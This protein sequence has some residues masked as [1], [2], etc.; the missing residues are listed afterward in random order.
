[1]SF[2]PWFALCWA[3]HY[4]DQQGETFLSV[5]QLDPCEVIAMSPS[6]FHRVR[7]THTCMCTCSAHFKHRLVIVDV[8]QIQNPDPRFL[9]QLRLQTL[10]A[11]FLG[12]ETFI[13]RTYSVLKVLLVLR[14]EDEVM[15][16]GARTL[17]PLAAAVAGGKQVQYSYYHTKEGSWQLL[18]YPELT[19]Q[20][21]ADREDHRPR[22][23]RSPYQHPASSE[24]CRS[25]RNVDSTFRFGVWIR[26]CTGEACVCVWVKSQCFQYV[27][28][29]PHFRSTHRQKKS[30]GVEEKI[31]TVVDKHPGLYI[32]TQDGSG[33]RQTWVTLAE[34]ILI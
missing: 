16:P 26:R 19:A 9:N 24:T 25:L 10:I 18:S 17:P 20:S 34:I 33:S 8:S 30:A 11:S 32:G 21:G 15:K 14:L 7:H 28:I 27:Q 2:Y 22:P 5:L 29:F 31:L 1:M 3:P 12:D 6:A 13:V 4:R 23:S